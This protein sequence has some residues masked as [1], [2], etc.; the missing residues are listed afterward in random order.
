MHYSE[1]SFTY[2]T[3]QVRYIAFNVNEQAEAYLQALETLVQLIYIGRTEQKAL[4]TFI[5]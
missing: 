4:N 5:L 1:N 2:A 3:R